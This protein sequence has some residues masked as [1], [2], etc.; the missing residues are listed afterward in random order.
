MLNRIIGNNPIINDA[1]V[2][3]TELVIDSVTHQKPGSKAFLNELSKQSH[4]G[5]YDGQEFP[6]A[7]GIIEVK[8][9][10]SEPNQKASLAKVVFEKSG[11]KQDGYVIRR[12]GFAKFEGDKKIAM[13]LYN[14]FMKEPQ[15]DG[16]NPKKSKAKKPTSLMALMEIFER[17]KREE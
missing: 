11:N 4:N 9:I 8:E 10:I 3:N 15:G 14:S 16:K 2:P 1:D 6:L 5:M 13:N 17:N 7:G 12:G